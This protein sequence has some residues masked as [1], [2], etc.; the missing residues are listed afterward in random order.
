M[1]ATL[2]FWKRLVLKGRHYLF[3]ESVELLQNHRLGCAEYLADVNRAQAGVSLL[4]TF[5]FFDYQFRRP[6]EPR[7]QAGRAIVARCHFL[8]TVNV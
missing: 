2:L 6:A 3:G 4:D 1:S 8:S 7:C 5:E